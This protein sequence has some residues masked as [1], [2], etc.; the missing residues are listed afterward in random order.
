ML[1]LPAVVTAVQTPD[2]LSDM[3]R[4]LADTPDQAVI[5]LDASAVTQLDSSCVAL[6]LALQRRAQASGRGIRVQGASAS[7]R[8]LV[9]AYG[10]ETLLIEASVTG[11]Q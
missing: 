3:S 2:L 9:C 10:L 6:L 5:D 11:A 7:L 4:A 1:R 8:A